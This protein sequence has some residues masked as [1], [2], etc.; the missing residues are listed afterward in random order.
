LFH[1]IDHVD[2]RVSNLRAVE[3]FYDALLP[4]LGLRKRQYVRVKGDEWTYVTREQ[5]YNAVEYVEEPDDVRSPRFFG[6][7]EDAAFVPSLT[8]ISFAIDA[9]ANLQETA[10]F[11]RA[12][13]ARNVEISADP[14]T[15]PA[16][17]FEDPLGS[18][19]EVHAV[20]R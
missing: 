5:P 4:W 3:A 18:R 1:G 7:V 9:N 6:V 16:V 13:G 19:F 8:R 2:S 20:S 12:A 15:Y 11:L 17:F 10:E 14:Q